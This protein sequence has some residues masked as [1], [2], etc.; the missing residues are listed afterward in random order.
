MAADR[1]GAVV[2]AVVAGL[3]AIGQAAANGPVGWTDQEI[4]VVL[5]SDIRSTNV[6]VNRDGNTDTVM[7]HI[8]EG[9]V[10]FRE[11]LSVAP[12]LAERYAVLDDG[13]T[14]RF[15]LRRG[16]RF[17]NGAEM[18]AEEV[19]W[20]YDRLLDPAT[21]HR[22]ADLF[23]GRT[24]ISAR[25]VSVAVVDRHTVD[26]TLAEP[27]PIFLTSLANTQCNLGILHPGSLDDDGTWRAPVGT[28]PYRLAEWRRGEYILLERFD[29]YRP[30]DG[31][32]DGYAGRRDPIAR[33]LRF[34]II[35]DAAVAIAAVQVGEADL[36][37]ALP[38]N[39]IEG[40][41]RRTD[42]TFQ[43][44]ELLSWNVLL[45]R[46]DDPTLANPDLRRAIAHAIDIDAV[47]EFA[48]VG[49]GRA[50]PSAHSPALPGYSDVH[51]RR[52]A[53]DP[54]QARRLLRQ[55][56]YRG[57]RLVIQTNKRFPTMY[58][59]AVVIHAM[60]TAAG[61]HAEIEVLDYAT[62]LSNFFSGTF[63]LSAFAYSGRAHGAIR[64][65]N[66][67][68][69]RAQNA[70]YQWDSPRAFALAT[71]AF[72]RADSPALAGVLEEM[73]LAMLEDLPLI[74]L[75]NDHEVSMSTA[76]LEGYRGW[77]LGRPRLWGVWKRDRTGAREGN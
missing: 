50:N 24:P 43:D 1:L 71:R 8:V 16:V 47:A 69:P 58:D 25:I 41:R 27:T 20:S 56:G 31:G 22:C 32:K 44:Q 77:P 64:Y 65:A 59:N 40:A 3:A 53:Y 70:R 49:L 10:A 19:K 36:M 62:Q 61:I 15:H 37:P 39:M 51:L 11:D 17:H 57:E 67:I 23:N 75:Y 68:G 33:H 9:L 45:M 13:R 55:A 30:R 34:L 46:P 60:L 72:A 42:L 7:H 66:F 2:V 73:H 26:L 38:P 21:R 76:T 54:G 12:M 14:Y 52:P 18:T 5:N 29:G 35:P 4:R 63:Q 6:G 48:T 74:G 28:G